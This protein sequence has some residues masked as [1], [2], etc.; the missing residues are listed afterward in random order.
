MWLSN[1]RIVLPDRVLE[2]G[3]IC[4]EDGRIVDIIE[5]D[6]PGRSNDVTYTPRLTLIPG[7][8]DLHGDM[9]EREIEP[10]PGAHFPVEMALIE[11]DKRLAANGVTTAYA[12]ISFAEGR[13]RNNLRS[14]EHA[15]EIVTAT[16]R[17][18]H[19][20]RVDMRVHAR[21]EVT[22]QNAPP[23]LMELIENNQVQII[24]LTDHTPGQGQYRDIERF[25]STMAEWRKV[26]TESSMEFTLERIRQAQMTPPAWDVV[27]NITRIA[28]Q[29]GL[30]I[31]SHDDDTLNKVELMANLGVTISEFPVT[32]EAAQEA[33]QRGMSVVMGA[34]NALRGLST[35]GNLSA[36][37][38]IQDGLVDIL[39]A[40]YHPGALLQ[41]AW[42]ITRRGL[43][44]LH[45][46]VNLVTL[47][48]A[49]A[50]GFKERGSISLGN[51]ADFALVDFQRHSNH[52]RVRGTFR[53]GVPIYLDN[54]L[55]QYVTQH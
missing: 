38:A 12:A 51:Y 27:R 25:V 18:S 48:P 28:T 15:R 22:N 31:A 13:P 2:R 55:T 9:L 41:A 43:L 3:A 24:S 34:P 6:W 17:L 33:K 50:M 40:D 32:S 1:L 7:I 8:I 4:I 54:Y 21:F 29:Q 37:D 11:L 14:E 10:R 23:I 16:N 52:P 42:A 19:T 49:R 46:A 30:I 47:N 35:S 5:G 39:A 45:E 53:H 26:S 44:P 20:L 36:Q